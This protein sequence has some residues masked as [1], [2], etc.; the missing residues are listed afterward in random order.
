M[1]SYAVLVSSVYEP[2]LV[3]VAR[4]TFLLI[5]ALTIA[6][7]TLAVH[8]T[9]AANITIHT[10]PIGN[11]GNAPDARSGLGAVSY[12]YRIGFA[13]VTN[14]QYAAFL[15]AKAKSDPLELY[16]INM[17]SGLGGI[18]R[19]GVSGSFTYSTIVGRENK[20]V[21]WIS[22]YDAVR[23]AN[24][25]HNG[26]GSGDT[27]S[28]AYTLLGGTPTPSNGDTIKRNPG[29]QWFLPSQ[30]EWV[31]AGYHKNDG[32]TNNY[33]LFPMRSDIQ[34][35]PEP[36]RGGINSANYDK[37]VNDFTNVVSYISSSSPYGTFDQG[38]NVWEWNEGAVPQPNFVARRIRGGSITSSYH[39]LYGA[40]SSSA[41]HPGIED[42]TFSPV[43]GF[44]IATV[45]EPS[46]LALA[47]M[48]LVGGLLVWR[49]RVPR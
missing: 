39:A 12:D 21:N 34:P 7:S 32:V 37:A 3:F 31:K 47:C 27:E 16:N 33:Y 20:P 43:T 11:A 25:L 24:W 9:E 49:V 38:G 17:G 29:A 19:E 36:P 13:E 22:W 15:N 5:W 10:V 41:M 6:L 1:I 42:T 14:F 48:A 4:Y 45:P 2:L 30:D 8:C 23:F 26:Q 44:R 18:T 46:S 35:I 40:Q 28:G